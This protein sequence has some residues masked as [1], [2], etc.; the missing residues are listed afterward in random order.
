M[1]KTMAMLFAGVSLAAGLG[2]GCYAEVTPEAEYVEAPGPELEI[3]TYPQYE[4]QGQT[5]YLVND[6]WYTRHGR[7]WAYYR[8]EPVELHRRRA[9]V[10]VARP[11]RRAP[12]A[13]R[14]GRHEGRRDDRRDDHEHR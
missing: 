5:V 9:Y 3:A 11:V 7:G 12:P 10:Q 8:S 6:R 1:S 14:E 13:R 2:T 4:Y